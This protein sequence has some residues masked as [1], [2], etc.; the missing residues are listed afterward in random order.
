MD[1]IEQFFSDNFYAPH[2]FC[3]LWLPEIV[4]LHVAADLLIAL[5]YFSIPLAL[6]YFARR[7]PDMPFNSVLILFATFITLCGIT[8]LMGIL[9]LWRPFYGI[10]GL[11]MLLTGIVSSMTA[12]FVWKMMPKA[13]SLPSPAQLQEMN[14][15]LSASYDEIEAKVRERTEELEIVNRELVEAKERAEHAS[16]AKSEFLT[17]MSHEIRTPMNAILG[18]SGILSTSSPLTARQSEFISTLQVSARSLL[19]LIDDLL[20]ISKIETEAF[21]LERIPFSVMSEIDDVFR[22]TSPLAAQKGLSFTKQI[23]CQCIDKRVFIGDPKR[24][25][26]IL[27]NLVGNAIKFTENG[28]V[29]ISVRCA[30][31]E[32]RG[33][34]EKLFI[35]VADTGVGIAPEK[36]DIIFDKF[37]QAD[38]SIS[39]K[40]G[41]SGLGLSI[42]RRLA[43]LMGGS[44]GVE[45]TLGTGT[46]FTLTIP[47]QIASSQVVLAQP[48]DQ[49]Y[50][51]SHDKIKDALPILLVDDYE[52]NLLVA[53]TFLEQ[54]GYEWVGAA[55]GFEAYEKF[56]DAL[57]SLVLMDVQM[58]G[59]DGFEATERIRRLEKDNKLERSA[60]IGMTAHALAGDRER[61]LAAGMDDYI[62]KPFQPDELERLIRKYARPKPV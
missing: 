21:Q 34:M 55:N 15:K 49:K 50:V 56:R 25:R 2:G 3:F 12:F 24:L 42:T 36:L 13:L 40:Y 7:R 43:E 45:S 60:I 51:V 39:R 26:Q 57:F 58:P 14:A 28:T 38:L 8:H 48:G 52:P 59:M 33:D 31:P 17:N 47:L 19:S 35:T 41:G 18:L 11:I 9:V 53:G 62:A 37:V 5:S 32:E 1:R 54:F 46:E 44:V 30:E 6:W 4:W 29:R 22:I 10:E 23:E 61:C 20:D 27:L 16:Q